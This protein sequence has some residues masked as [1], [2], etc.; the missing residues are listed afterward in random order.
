MHI[1][2][3]VKGEFVEE[4]KNVCMENAKQSVKEKAIRR[5]DVLQQADDLTR[6]LLVEAYDDESGIDAHKKTAH[7]N[8]WRTE[9]E[10]IVEGERVRTK[11]V[12]VWPEKY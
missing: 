10:R 2:I 3:K 12:P 9:A 1:N 6:F 5:F 7:Y 4:F 11:F 8:K